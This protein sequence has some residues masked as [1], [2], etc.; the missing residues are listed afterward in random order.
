MCSTFEAVPLDISSVESSFL[1]FKKSFE[2]NQQDRNKG[3]QII[4]HH[5]Q[6]IPSYKPQQ[7]KSLN[8]F[9]LYCLLMFLSS[10]NFLHFLFFMLFFESGHYKK[11]KSC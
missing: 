5:F 4:S 6:S 3:E 1:Q 9:W 10:L 8:N 2:G 11:T 7:E